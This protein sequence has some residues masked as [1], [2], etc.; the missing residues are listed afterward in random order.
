MFVM[1]RSA[2]YF[3]YDDDIL[4]LQGGG[5]GP[6]AKKGEKHKAQKNC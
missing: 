6:R 4:S 3:L 5:V 2:F 1:I